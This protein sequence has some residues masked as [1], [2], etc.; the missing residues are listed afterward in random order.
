M[1]QQ[2]QQQPQN[3]H[4]H[5]QMKTRSYFKIMRQQQQ[6]GNGSI[7]NFNTNASISSKPGMPGG[8][9]AFQKQPDG[10]FRAPYN[11]TQYIMH[12]YSTRMPSLKQL[13]CP[14]EHQQFSNDWNMALLQEA[15]TPTS[16]AVNFDTAAAV[17][18]S[19]NDEDM[20]MHLEESLPSAK[21]SK[22]ENHLPA[23][24]SS[25]DIKLESHSIEDDLNEMTS[26]SQLFSTS[27]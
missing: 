27:I 4:A 7:S 10:K 25:I 13:T 17:D 18:E 1:Q 24:S 11:T 15:I 16:T 22:S 23:S 2:Q 8:G 21:K 20:M 12:D 26:S 19:L 6:L 14:D 9:G 3:Q 5:S